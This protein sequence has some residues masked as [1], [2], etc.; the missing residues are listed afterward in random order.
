MNL[1]EMTHFKPHGRPEPP[2]DEAPHEWLY[3]VIDGVKYKRETNTMP[4]WAGS[5]WYYLR[6]L[7]PKND[8]ALVDPDS[9]RPGCRSICISAAPSMPCCTCSTPGSGTRC[10]SI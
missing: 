2:L 1:P 10:Y 5:C 8:Q 9:K 6:F 4:Q 7:D 3:P